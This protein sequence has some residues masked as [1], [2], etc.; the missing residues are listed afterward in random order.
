[1]AIAYDVARIAPYTRC[2]SHS[3]VSGT[4]DTALHTSLTGTTLCWPAWVQLSAFCCGDGALYGGKDTHAAP[5]RHGH[6][7][8][9]HPAILAAA[10]HGEPGAQHRMHTP[11]VHAAAPP[12]V[13]NTARARVPGA[14]C[15]VLRLSQNRDVSISTSTACTSSDPVLLCDTAALDTQT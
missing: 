6:R 13:P 8:D 5:C 3:T 1:M 15:A 4:A 14:C 9:P 7:T 10:L 12:E 11:P 2:T